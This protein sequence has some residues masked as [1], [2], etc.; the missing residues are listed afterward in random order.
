M[1]LKTLTALVGS[2]SLGTLVGGCATSKAMAPAPEPTAEEAHEGSHDGAPGTHGASS[3]PTEGPVDTRKEP[4]SSNTPP[5]GM[6]VTPAKAPAGQPA[7]AVPAVEKSTEHACGAGGCGTNGC[8][9]G[10]K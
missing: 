1:N 4:Q 2:L 10:K 7:Q 6:S 8:G 3:V 9:G 5:S